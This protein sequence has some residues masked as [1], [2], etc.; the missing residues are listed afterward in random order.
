MSLK[1]K[2]MAGAAVLLFSECIG[3]DTCCLARGTRVKTPD[4][5]TP[6]EELEKGDDVLAW[7]HGSSDYVKTEVTGT[8]KARREVVAVAV[9]NMRLRMTSDHHVWSPEEQDYKPVGD[10]V[11]GD[12]SELLRTTRGTEVVDVTD[13]LA[14]DGVTEVFNISVKHDSRNYV[15]DG[16]VVQNLPD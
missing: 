10:W 7:D 16:F 9:G 1:E 13:R 3:H 15:A 2:M 12:L 14:Y 4:G 8:N 6:I 11:T 5:W